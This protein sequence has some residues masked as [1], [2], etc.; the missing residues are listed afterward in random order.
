MGKN[1][2]EKNAKRILKKEERLLFLYDLFLHTKEPDYETIISL[3]PYPNRRMF[4][5]DMKEL[6]ACGLIRRKLNR[7]G[8]TYYYEE[9]SDAVMQTAREGSS[10]SRK[11]GNT[12]G[13]A[14]TRHMER[15]KRLA[16]LMRELE[17]AEEDIFALNEYRDTIEFGD[18]EEKADAAVPDV[19]SAKEL[20]YRLVP[21]A[22]ERLRQRDFAL[23]NRVGYQIH[24]DRLTDKY[25]AYFPQQLADSYGLVYEDGKIRSD[26]EKYDAW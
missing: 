21:H 10:V 22:T 26:P 11:K 7:H 15:L 13:K 20:Y 14:E 25:I 12:A 5:R 8:E 16:L 1:R 17:T 24:Y 9:R 2:E 18:E 23:L 4:Q 3:I 6:T 19:L